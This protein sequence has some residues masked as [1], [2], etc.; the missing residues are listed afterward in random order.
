LQVDRGTRQCLTG[1]CSSSPR[2]FQIRSRPQPGAAT[3]I[4]GLSSPMDGS[5]GS[6]AVARNL[7]VRPPA[8]YMT[9]AMSSPPKIESGKTL[10]LGRRRGAFP[11]LLADRRGKAGMDDLQRVGVDRLPRMGRDVEVPASLERLE[12]QDVDVE[13]RAYAARP[14]TGER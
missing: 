6:R 14:V 9:D 7:V 5:H 10:D 8:P 13:R 1:Q 3:V 4:V 12:Y 2:T 11:Y